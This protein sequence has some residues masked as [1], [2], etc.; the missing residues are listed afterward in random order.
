[1]GCRECLVKIDVEN[2]DAEITRPGD[3]HHRVEI[4]AIHV[5]KAAV[6]MNNLGHFG[7]LILK[8]AQSIRI[9]DHETG[10]IIVPCIRRAPAQSS[11]P[12]KPGKPAQNADRMVRMAMNLLGESAFDPAYRNELLQRM[13]AESDAGVRM[14]LLT[15]LSRMDNAQTLAASPYS[16]ILREINTKG[17]ES[18]FKKKD[19]GL[20]AING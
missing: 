17:K 10:D 3:P 19:R 13:A 1:M 8:Y 20:F 6:R 7:N 16:A 4:G 2:V 12:G 11:V 9:R 5:H 14:E 18:R 15:E